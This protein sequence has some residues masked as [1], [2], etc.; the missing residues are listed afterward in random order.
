[1][2]LYRIKDKKKLWSKDPREQR[3]ARELDLTNSSVGYDDTGRIQ[4]PRA[5]EPPRVEEVV[6]DLIREAL[7]KFPNR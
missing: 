6:S 2:A 7:K 5:N 3:L 1:M 4:T